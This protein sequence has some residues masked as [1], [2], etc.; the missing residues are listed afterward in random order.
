VEPEAVVIA[1][2]I[3]TAAAVVKE[4]NEIA[5]H[6]WVIDGWVIETAGLHGWVIAG[7]RLCLFAPSVLR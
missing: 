5:L 7:L 1:M 2:V 4:V 6:G 3:E